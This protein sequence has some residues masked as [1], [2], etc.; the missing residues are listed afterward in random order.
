MFCA[1][2]WGLNVLCWSRVAGDGEV[3]LAGVFC[4]SGFGELVLS[5][6]F[7]PSFSESPLSPI[8]FKLVV[9]SISSIS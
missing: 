1:G 5:C 7:S 8:L 3:F 4:F 6:F 2:F 9:V